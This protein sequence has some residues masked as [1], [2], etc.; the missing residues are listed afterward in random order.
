MCKPYEA[1]IERR[2]KMVGRKV[3]HYDLKGKRIATYFTIAEAEKKAKVNAADIHAVV[4]GKQRS[5]GGY[6][7][8]K[9]FGKQAINV[10]GYLVGEAWRA[11]RR[12]K[13]VAKYNL[14]GKP[15]ESFESVKQAAKEEKIS[16][17]YISM[18]VKKQLIVR[19]FLWRFS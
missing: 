18:A 12:Q 2:N 11:W 8:T 10:K 14:K 7:W 15:I 17:G 6:I 19:N 1:N 5:A 16:P 9:G 13:K 3:T 4:N